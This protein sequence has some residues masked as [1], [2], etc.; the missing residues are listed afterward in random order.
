MTQNTAGECCRFSTGS[1]AN[2][3]IL[4]QG[5]AQGRAAVSAEIKIESIQGL[6][7][8]AK[9]HQAAVIVAV[10]QIQEM[11]QFM[12]RDL[13]YPLQYTVGGR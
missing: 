2:G 6:H 1:C 12:Q 4:T 11:P 8:T 5:T 3:A 9:M 7:P 10:Q 13:A